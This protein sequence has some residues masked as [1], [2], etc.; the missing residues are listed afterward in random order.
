MTAEHYPDC[1]CG[2]CQAIRAARPVTSPLEQVIE[3]IQQTLNTKKDHNGTTPARGMFNTAD[4]ATLLEL[5]K[6]S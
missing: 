4:I 6:K 5:V 1:P 2:T 3:R